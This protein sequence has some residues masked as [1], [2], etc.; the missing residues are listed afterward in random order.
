MQANAMPTANEIFSRRT[1]PVSWSTA[2]RAVLAMA[3]EMLP[4]IADDLGTDLVEH[5]SLALVDQE[6]ALGAVRLVLAASLERLHE[7][8]VENVRLK[9]RLGDL[10]DADRRRRHGR[11]G[12]VRSQVQGQ[13]QVQAQGQ[14]K[15][16]TGSTTTTTRPRTCPS[17]NARTGQAQGQATK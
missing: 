9:R 1:Q 2:T 6:E 11:P 12:I 17:T 7:Q 3:I 5:V 4:T 16:I 15:L 8:H 10:L 14:H 13:V